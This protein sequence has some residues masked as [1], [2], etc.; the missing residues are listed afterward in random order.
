M[1]RRERVWRQALAGLVLAVGPSCARAEEVALLRPAAGVF[2]FNLNSAAA[3]ELGLQ[4][5]LGRNTGPIHPLIGV[6][7]TTDAAFLVYAGFGID[8]P[9]G[10]PVVLRPSLAPG[11]YHR[12]EGK[13]LGSIIEYRSALEVAWR[14]RRGLRV[15]VELDHVSNAGS[16]PSNRGAESLTLTISI[17]VGGRQRVAGGAP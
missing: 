11:F 16:A 9:L 7:G 6:F 15:G 17:P 10:G 1:A 12:G 4:Y 13:D 3:G 5:R 8:I 2:E 14:T